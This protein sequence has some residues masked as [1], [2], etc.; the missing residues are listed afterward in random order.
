M[1]KQFTREAADGWTWV[2]R[3]NN[4]RSDS[5]RSKEDDVNRIS[6][7]IFVTNF[8]ESFTAKDLF[9]SCKQYGHVVDSFI[10]VK[11]SKE[12][13]RF[14]FVRFINVF[15][16]ERLV[17]NLCTIWVDRYKFHANLARFQRPPLKSA[18]TYVKKSVV[19]DRGVFQVPCKAVG[20]DGNGNSF[21]DAVKSGVTSRMVGGESGGESSPAIVLGD[22]CLNTKDVSNA[23]LGRVKEFASLTNIKMALANEGFIELNIRYMGELWVLL[24]FGSLK[25]KELFQ[26][27]T[28]VGSWFSELKQASLDFNIDGRIVWVEIEG[29]P[30]KLWSGNTFKRL[31]AKWGDLLDVDDQEEICFHSKRICLY[32]KYHMNILESFK[33]IFRGKVFWIRAK[34]VPGWVPKLLEDSEDEEHSEDGS[35]EGDNKTQ[36]VGSND[37]VAEMRSKKERRTDAIVAANELYA[38]LMVTDPCSLIDNPIAMN[39]VTPTKYS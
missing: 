17:S 38:L 25:S 6:T 39:P 23:L 24:E 34:E 29:V 27:H 28:G 20:G 31:A 7:S 35:V 36:D 8:P 16:V 37:D 9:H 30:F 2:F 22:E 26:E 10:P 33:M 19:Q 12:G 14:R 15:N 11:R 18:K 21:V 1:G 13:K 5:F 32:T 4:K 3:G